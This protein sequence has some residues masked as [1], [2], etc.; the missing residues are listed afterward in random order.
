MV[1]AVGNLPREV[2]DKKSGVADPASC[3]VED[4]R[5]GERLM[6]ALVSQN[7]ETGTKETLKDSVYS[8]K[9]S[10]DWGQRNVFWSDE[11][12]EDHEGDCQTGDVP[13]NIAQTPQ[14]RSLEAVFGNCTSNI[15]DRVIWKLELVSIRIN[16]LAVA[17]LIHIVQRGH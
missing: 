13:S 15:V 14:T 10:S 9:P 3:V 7:P 1:L 4:L 17:L 11:F 5:W 6:T 2:W 16:E 12:I 8:P